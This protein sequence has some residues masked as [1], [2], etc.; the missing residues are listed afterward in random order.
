MLAKV[1]GG[2]THLASFA[3]AMFLLK[4]SAQFDSGSFKECEDWL[5]D[6][7][8]Q[9]GTDIITLSDSKESE[10][11]HQSIPPGKYNVG[12]SLVY[13]ESEIKPIDRV[14]EVDIYES[15]NVLGQRVV[16]T[17]EMIS[18]L[19][20]NENTVASVNV[21]MDGLAFNQKTRRIEPDSLFA[22]KPVFDCDADTFYAC[23]KGKDKRKHWS[24]FFKNSEMTEKIRGWIKQ[25]PKNKS[26]LMRRAGS[27]E[28]ITARSDDVLRVIG[29]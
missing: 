5:R 18:P 14:L 21:S 20:L 22:G 3:A 27:N 6:Y 2:A 19:G 17:K 24:K 26:F 28:Y 25:S 23:H 12:D 16:F 9:S 4:E 11:N 13:I 10:H 7:L 15:E 8:M 1:P 29:G